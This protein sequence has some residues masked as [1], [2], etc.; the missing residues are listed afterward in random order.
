MEDAMKKDM[1]EV[2]RILM[3]LRATFNGHQAIKKDGGTDMYPD[4]YYAAIGHSH[5][6]LLKAYQMFQ[7]MEKITA[8][9]LEQKTSN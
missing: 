6:D 3:V 4:E 2:Y 1:K 5:N 7:V 9:D 8:L